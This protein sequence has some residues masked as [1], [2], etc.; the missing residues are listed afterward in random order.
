MARNFLKDDNLYDFLDV[1]AAFGELHAP[2]MSE[3]NVL[4]FGHIDAPGDIRFDYR[5]TLIPPKKYLF[6]PRETVLTYSPEEGYRLP[7]LSCREIVLLGLHPCDL[8]GIA[9]LDNV[10]GTNS[11]DPLYMQRRHNL[12]LVGVSCEPD[13]FCFCGG[14]DSVESP[15]DLFMHRIAGGYQITA[16]SPRGEQIVSRLCPHL[17]E[18][19][20]LPLPIQHGALHEGI[21]S[22]CSAG[23][24]F[25]ESPMWDDFADRCLSCGAC[26]LCCPTCYCFDVREYGGLDGETAQRL[27][28]WDNCLF[29]EHGE[30]AGGFSF[31]KERRER[32]RYRYRHK[33]LGFGPTLGVVACVGCGRCRQV[34]PVG[35]DLL[36]LFRESG[37]E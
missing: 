25:N 36:D 7:F 29:K 37:Y 21:L 33:Y 15:S 23:E 6:P 1:L 9:Y 24:V 8:A 14:N 35:I 31:R 17:A 13:E 16:G 3:D 12:T 5:R 28:E 34:C 18:Q 20:S 27:R 2:V 10:F 22:A 19:E 30:V 4:I 32:F 11:L 26:S